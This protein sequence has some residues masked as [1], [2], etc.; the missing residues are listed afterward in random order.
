MFFIVIAPTLSTLLKKLPTKFVIYIAPFTQSLYSSL[1]NFVSDY[2]L[3][4]FEEYT[5]SPDITTNPVDYL[6]EQQ[7]TDYES[8]KD[9]Q[10]IPVQQSD[11][12]QEPATEVTDINITDFELVPIQQPNLLSKIKNEKVTIT[13][14]HFMTTNNGPPFEKQVQA[15]P[16]LVVVQPCTGSTGYPY[17][18]YYPR[19]NTASPCQNAQPVYPSPVMMGNGPL[20]PQPNTYNY[21]AINPVLQP[22]YVPPMESPPPPINQVS[23]GNF[24]TV[25]GSNYPQRPQ[26]IPPCYSNCYS[27]FPANAY[28]ANPLMNIQNRP[29]QYAIPNA[30]SS[31]PQ[32]PYPLASGFRANYNNHYLVYIKI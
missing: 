19:Q 13:G 14:I 20:P 7:L 21:G 9:F 26:L 1:P 10:L 32:Q 22:F 28:A 27:A 30:R 8:A 18:Y 17:P 5:K 23:A 25:G 4:I 15:P 24:A 29:P 11:Y 31:Y 2:I 3:T 6:Q 16:L 12:Y